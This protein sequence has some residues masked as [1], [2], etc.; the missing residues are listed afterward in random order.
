MA[1]KI[2]VSSVRGEIKQL[3]EESTGDKKRN[4]VETVSL[5]SLFFWPYGASEFLAADALLS[6]VP[7]TGR[8]A[9]R[10]EELRP[11]A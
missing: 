8:V 10:I 2:S 6:L 11:P 3:L 9:N 7:T 5:P 4:F 1:S